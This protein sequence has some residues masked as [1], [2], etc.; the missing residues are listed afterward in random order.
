M[1]NPAAAP[2][3]IAKQLRAPRLLQHR[4]FEGPT[5]YY[6]PLGRPLFVAHTRRLLFLL[7]CIASKA[8][9]EIFRASFEL[10]DQR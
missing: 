4:R 1:K 5:L 6:D 9:E 8:F 3:A 10:P 2:S 7:A